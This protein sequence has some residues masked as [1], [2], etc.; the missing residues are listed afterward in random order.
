MKENMHLKYLEY[1]CK[2]IYKTALIDF[3]QINNEMCDFGSVTHITMT[4]HI[5]LV[6]SEFFE[7]KGGRVTLCWLMVNNF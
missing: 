3:R 6:F 4:K 5:K 7:N 1:V 2:Y